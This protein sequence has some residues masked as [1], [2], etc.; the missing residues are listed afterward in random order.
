M[1]SRLTI[2]FMQLSELAGAGFNFYK[3]AEMEKKT[4]GIYKLTLVL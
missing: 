3:D 2:I 4:V 1:V